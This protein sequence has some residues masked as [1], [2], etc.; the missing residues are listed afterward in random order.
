MNYS[1]NK[2]DVVDDIHTIGIDNEKYTYESI[3]SETLVL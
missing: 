2:D 1:I 3:T